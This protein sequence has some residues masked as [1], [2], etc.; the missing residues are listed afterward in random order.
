MKKQSKTTEMGSGGL[1]YEQIQVACKNIGHDL[2]CGACAAIFFTGVGLPWDKHSCDKSKEKSAA[3]T[4]GALMRRID[5]LE[6][7]VRALADVASSASSFIE[8][9]QRSAALTV[10]H[11]ARQAYI[12]HMRERVS[13]EPGGVNE[14]AP[15]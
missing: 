15:E 5:R 12:D 11:G 13:R 4:M 7:M 3:E 8:A 9:R 6:M 2:S 14:G 10:L 1:T